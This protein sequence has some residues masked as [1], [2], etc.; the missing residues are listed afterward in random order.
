M[1]G[2][3]LEQMECPVIGWGT[4]MGDLNILLVLVAEKTLAKRSWSAVM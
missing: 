4:V 3:R 1:K 2:N